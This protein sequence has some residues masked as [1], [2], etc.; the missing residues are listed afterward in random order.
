MYYEIIIYYAMQLLKMYY[1]ITIN[2]TL[3]I[4]IIILCSYYCLLQFYLLYNALVINYAIQLYC[5]I[6]NYTTKLS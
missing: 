2:C 3:K 5:S 4:L 1:V 6:I